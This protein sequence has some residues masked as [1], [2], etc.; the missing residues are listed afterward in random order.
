MEEVLEGSVGEVGVLLVN[1]SE[2]D[3]IEVY[4]FFEGFLFSLFFI[5][6]LGFDFLCKF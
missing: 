3:S 6:N 1:F 5:M 2:D 4:W